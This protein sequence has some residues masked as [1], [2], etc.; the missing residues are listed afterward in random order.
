VFYG[1]EDFEPAWSRATAEENF[2][3]VLSRARPKE[4]AHDYLERDPAGASS[5]TVEQQVATPAPSTLTAAE[6]LRQRADQVAER[7]AAER[8]QERAAAAA[9]EQQR[10]QEQ[11]H[12]RTLERSKAKERELSQDHDPGLEL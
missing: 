3:S 9:L 11:Q 4:L 8:E 2:K 10:A 12:D 6:R 1:R 5:A 7:L